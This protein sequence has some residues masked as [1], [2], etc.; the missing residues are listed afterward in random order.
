MQDLPAPIR[1]LPR[2]PP[3]RATL[4]TATPTL[5]ELF[6]FM[7]EA[8]LRFGSLRMR[9]VD[10]Q[11][12]A[13]GEVVETYDIWLRH[14][15]QAKVVTTRGADG[16]RDFEAWI[17]DGERVRTYDARANTT[18][19]RPQPARPVGS[20][21]ARLPGFAR[22]YVPVTPLPPES[23]ADT[24]VHPDGFT[25]NVLATGATRQTGTAVL[26][27][28]EAILLRCDHPRTSHVP[29]DRPDHWLEVGVD[30]QTGL[31]LLLA[32]HVGGGLT[33]RA[34]VVSI[35]LDEPIPDSA[36]KLHVSAGT[37]TLY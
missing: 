34:E 10:Q 25:K 4:A 37:R 18:A 30:R 9:I 12:N 26:S 32:E 27:G 16:G 14:P 6:A 19:V 28:R 20:T 35:G 15:A 8:E 24:F 31:M 11:V 21:D 7:A 13:R 23:L 3:Q 17:T 36:F 2:R 22:L 29:T 5:A 33:R 1:T